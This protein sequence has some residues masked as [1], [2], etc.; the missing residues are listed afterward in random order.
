MNIEITSFYAA[1]L[2]LWLIV[3]SAR[4]IAYRRKKLVALGHVDDRAL[5]WR[6]RA[7]ANLTEYAPIALILL[8]TIEN[9][10]VSTWAVHGLG[11][12]LLLGRVFHGWSFS[13]AG[14]QMR[15]RIIGMLLTLTMVGVSSLLVLWISAFG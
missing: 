5:E 11:V 12:L 3:L 8:G 6:V 10:G 1:L 7:Q 9:S 4:V 15:F 14:G 2:G 13:F